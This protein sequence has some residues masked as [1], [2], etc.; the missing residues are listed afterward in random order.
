MTL[1]APGT[2]PKHKL[3][4][5]SQME[6]N[7]CLPWRPHKENAVTFTVKCNLLFNMQQ[8]EMKA[9]WNELQQRAVRGPGISSGESRPCKN[10]AGPTH[11]TVNWREHT[12]KA[13]KRCL[14]AQFFVMGP[15]IELC[16]IVLSHSGGELSKVRNPIL[17]NWPK[18]TIQVLSVKVLCNI[19]ELMQT[20]SASPELFWPFSGCNK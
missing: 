2:L 3:H 18:E 8:T 15:E 4:V 19:S 12:S 14:R 9:S 6:T 13:E 10:C 1:E 16:D 17:I 7:G 5:C 20:G 11:C